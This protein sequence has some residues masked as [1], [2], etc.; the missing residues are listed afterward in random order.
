[1]TGDLIDLVSYTFATAF[2]PG[3]NNIVALASMMALG[4]RRS[5]PFLLGICIGM[6]ATMLVT[7]ALT[8]WVLLFFP[9]II[10]YLQFMGCVYLIWLSYKIAV[11]A[12]FDEEERKSNYGFLSGFILQV[13]NAKIILFTITA[14]SSFVIPAGGTLFFILGACLV[15]AAIACL[16]TLTWAVAGSLL[17]K[18][19][20]RHFR[21]VNIVMAVVLLYFAF[22]MVI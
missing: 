4:F 10:N 19:Y 20:L 13:L 18:A 12:R 3:P 17:K 2:T 16:G 7:G 8:S 21:T 6:S 11:S 15:S 5:A 1:M 14:I 22:K 9:N